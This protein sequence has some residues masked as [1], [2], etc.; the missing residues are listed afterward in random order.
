MI[1]L[2][3]NPKD[4]RHILVMHDGKTKEVKDRKGT[5]IRQEIVLLEKHLNQ[6]PQHMFLPSFSGIQRPVVFL[7]KKKIKDKWV[8]FCVRGLWYEIKSWCKKNNISCT[9]VYKISDYGKP[10]KEPDKSFQLSDFD[11]TLEEFDEYIKSWNLNLELRPY[12]VKAAWTMLHYKQSMSQLATR[13]GKTLIAYV[14]FRYMLEHGAKKILMI[15]PNINLVRQGVSDMK[16][17]KEFFR[18]EEIWAQG[19]YCECSN[20]TIGTFQSLIRRCSLGSRK[21]PNKHYNP[22]FFDNFDVV[23]VDECHKADC[24]SIKTIM[25]Q[26]FVRNAKIIFGFSGTIPDGGTIESFGVQAILGPMVQDISTMELVDA[27]Y[28][29]KPI[30]RQI[31][32]NHG[33]TPELH[34]KY[35]QYGEYL[36]GKD[37][38]ET[39]DVS[40]LGISKKK[41]LPLVLREGRDL[42]DDSEYERI[43]IDMCKAKGASL[44]NLEQLLAMNS[45]GKL[46]EILG[47]LSGWPDKNGIIFAHNE[48]YVDYLYKYLSENLDRPVYRIKGKT[49]NKKREEIKKKMNIE[50]N[51]AVLVASYGCV[52]TGLTFSNINWC[53]FAQSF[54][55]PITIMQSIGRGLLKSDEKDS[56]I[57]YDLIDIFP[58]GRLKKHGE[59]KNK[60]YRK[61]HYEHST[62]SSSYKYMPLFDA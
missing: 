21:K 3:Y 33:E 13:A 45:K 46:K 12:Q 2:Y 59:E 9:G 56:F 57:V 35:I 60:Q 25:K 36:C 42:Y 19:E 58:T 39:S 54:K 28:L 27:G 15:V 51:N 18:S 22:H 4:P 10:D 24:D 50:D 7:E 16:D 62:R 61:V 20:L 41:S 31:H 43:L 37:T 8:Y 53:I 44:L 52:A 49:S 32:I 14:I 6:I 1:E 26:E 40:D 30:V 38:G 23:C 11:M 17:Y 5:H 34:R 48:E 55:S 29:A 47:L